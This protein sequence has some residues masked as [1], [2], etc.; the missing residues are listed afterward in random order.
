MLP[1]G[2]RLGSYK[3]EKVLGE[4][5]MGFVYEATH[6]GLNRRCAI[7]ILR[8]ELSSHGHVV[9]RFLQEAK[10]VNVIDH[11]N[12]INVYDY[13]EAP[14]GDVF[15][16]MEYLEGE[17]LDDL[18]LK[19]GQLP[20]PLLIH[21]FTQT[22][23]ALAAAHAK[24]IVHRDLKP[25]N[26]FVVTRE[27]NPYFIKLLDFGIAQLRGEGEVQKGLTVAGTV[28]GTP[29]Y[30]SPE[31]VSG[32]VIDARTDVW[33]M[34]VMMYR[35]VTGRMPFL[36]E[37]FLQLAA[38]ILTD[39]PPRPRELNP[40]I[41]IEL[42]KLIVSCMDR[43]V[44]DRCQSIA[45]L[46]AG[47]ERVRSAAKIGDVLAEVKLLAGVP[48]TASAHKGL[49][50]STP[51]H[52]EDAGRS[53]QSAAAAP[54][55][56]R[57][58]GLLVGGGVLG[59]ALIGGV[60]FMLMRG[61][62]PPATAATTAPVVGSAATGS[63]TGSDTTA[64][65]GSGSA[66]GSIK[67]AFA[68]NDAVMV[69]ARAGATLQQALD[70]KTLQE[71]GQAV[72]AIAAVRNGKTAP[73]LYHALEGSPELRVKAARALGALALPDAVP[74]LR[75]ALAQSGDKVKV[76]LAA[77]LVRLGDKDATAILKR[78]LSDPGMRLVAATTL[79]E[80]GDKAALP[81][82]TEIFE[83]TP[84]GRE[85]WLRAAQ[86]LVKLGDAKALEALEAELVQPDALRAAMAAETLVAG[87]D[88]KAKDYLVRVAADPEFVQ[89]GRASAALA[90]LR[91]PRALDWVPTGL[92]SADVEERVLALSICGLLDTTNHDRE[93]AALAT[94]DPDRG[95]RLTAAAALL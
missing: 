91:D 72:D 34:G 63:A 59:L 83:T 30:M 1:A 65:A 9:T 27:D 45:E 57:N 22:A 24:Q 89:R 51:Q 11:P 6:Q 8:S 18:M 26:V 35:A 25:A 28:M 4:G 39:D 43:N 19:Q 36:G 76:E 41:S 67:D 5:G 29:D 14:G 10:A 7:K 87:G 21:T 31:Q 77:A 54:A 55:G 60:A 94:D 71:Q 81:V 84:A 38:Q 17:T 20:L 33:A 48:V 78:A 68:A 82:L 56:K 90:R 23:K 53:T 3:I 70:S 15:F 40:S 58:T 80:S 16:V 95:V 66:S 47:L 2:A 74:K 88:T 73:L 79:A 62:K 50:S 49:A 44:A 64:P 93:L 61:D 32:L 42:E 69:R 85:Q 86:A 46:L 13:G 37:G 92:A 52:R 12:I 75:A